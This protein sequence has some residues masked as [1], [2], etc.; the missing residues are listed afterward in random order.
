MARVHIQRKKVNE[1]IKEKRPKPEKKNANIIPPI[2][3]RR[4]KSK[5]WYYVVG[6]GVKSKNGK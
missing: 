2:V 1:N 4:L 3:M 5:K 6:T